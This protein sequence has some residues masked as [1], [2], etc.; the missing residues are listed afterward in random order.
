MKTIN[1]ILFD[2]SEN[3][4][5]HIQFEEYQKNILSA[6]FYKFLSYKIEK[7]NNKKLF[8]YDLNFEEAFNEENIDFYGEIIREENLKIL[9]YFINPSQLYKNLINEENKIEK[10]NEAIKNIEY[11]DENFKDLL[12][13]QTIDQYPQI[14]DY[15]ESILLDINT[16]K[17]D[18]EEITFLMKYFFRNSYTPTNISLLLSK[19]ALT[20]KKKI[21]N[22]YDATCGSCSTLLTLN[23]LEKVN[24]IYGQEIKKDNYDLAR[25]NLI[26]NNIS[27]EQFKIFNEDSTTSKRKLPQMDVIISHP[28]FLKKWDANEELLNDERFNSYKKLPSKSKASYAFLGTMVYQLKDDGIMVVVMPQGVLSRTNTEKEIRKTLIE[29]KN[30]IDAIIGLPDKSF[31]KNISTCILI[32]KKNRNKDDKILFIN[33]RKNFE[34]NNLNNSLTME[35]IDEIVNTYE[36][37][38][39]IEKYSYN[40]SLNDIKENDYNLNIK[41][42]VN[43]YNEKERI[44]IRHTIEEIESVEKEIII[45]KEKEKLLLEKLDISLEN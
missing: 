34:K 29:E 12:K 39:E 45:L 8:K 9:K 44:N 25:M 32:L 10:L 26:M 43:T 40:A 1:E 27:P 17:F 21:N 22:V 16:I 19:L 3:L 20:N 31:P 23:E 36:N 24:M 28:P 14:I 2:S 15:Y 18:K 11:N 37:K 5:G 33:S 35:H 4:R 6:I 38:L 41:R 7:E 30:Y 13:I 42:Y